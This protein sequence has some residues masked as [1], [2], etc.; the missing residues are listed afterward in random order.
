ME[1]FILA[2]GLGTR[3]SPVLSDLPKPMAPIAGKPFISYVLSRLSSQGISDITLCLGYK[4]QAFIDMLGDGAQFKVNLSYSIEN[5]PL[6]TGGALKKAIGQRKE[7][8][9][10]INGDTYFEC[11]LEPI[12]KYHLSHKNWITMA[13]KKNQG[14]E[15]RG[16]VEMSTNGVIESFIEK[17]LNPS[18]NNLINT[19]LYIFSGNVNLDDLPNKFSLERDYFPSLV[20]QHKLMG[21]ISRGYFID[22]GT[23][24]SWKKFE[25]DVLEGKI[26]YDHP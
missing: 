6:D 24:E 9:L 22:I 14:L 15:S 10:V 5:E 12:F 16:Y 1:A 11:D 25:N 13:L 7:P 3:L 4:H 19:G 2:G 8:T 18:S 23:P 21:Y 26:V 17:K 20:I